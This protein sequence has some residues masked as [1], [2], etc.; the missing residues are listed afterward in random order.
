MDVK[1][2]IADLAKIIESGLEKYWQQERF[3]VV[4][5]F[6]PDAEII[7]LLGKQ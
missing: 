2:T 5:V 6:A 1:K 4:D 7:V 3:P